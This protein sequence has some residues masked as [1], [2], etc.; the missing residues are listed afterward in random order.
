MNI[1]VLRE[2]QAGEARVALMPESIK[3]LVALK[4]TVL[5]ESGDGLSALEAT[6]NFAKRRKF[7]RRNAP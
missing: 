2:T 5:I 4:A 3:K 7:N 6:T 1:V